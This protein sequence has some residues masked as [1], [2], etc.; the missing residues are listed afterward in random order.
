MKTATLLIAIL[1]VL[2]AGPVSVFANDEGGK[3]D[4]EADCARCHGADGKG[5]GSVKRVPGYVSVDLTKLAANNGGQFPRQRIFDSIDGKMKVAA[6]FSGDMPRWGAKFASHE[7]D[8]AGHK[9]I[10]ALVDYIESMQQ[11]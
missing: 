7:Q 2:T 8:E 10:S 3:R 1:L 6:H 5:T 11:K 4:F 9:R